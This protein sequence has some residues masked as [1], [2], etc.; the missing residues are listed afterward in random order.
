MRK[1]FS[2]IELIF[3]IF[4]ILL[5]SS[6]FY[7]KKT[8]DKLQV[9]TERLILY[10]KQT[11]YQAL[12]DSKE[13][14]NNPLWHKKRWTFKFFRCRKRVGGFYY[15]IYSDENMKGH[16]GQDESLIDPLTKKRVYSTNSC[17][18][19]NK[20]SKYV[21][22]T[23]EFDI[24]DINIS[25]NKT[26]SVGQISFGNNGKIY[27][28]QSPKENLSFEFEIHNSC[29]ITLIDNKNQSSTIIIEAKTG[30]I[31]RKN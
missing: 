19:N 30:Y 4:L 25:C 29:E 1:S 12:I 22:L 16:P 28:K 18:V 24:K 17:K 10:L 23:K 6:F 8:E 9:A 3:T 31:F 15:T 20:N 14:K 13:E 11:R 27:A 2:L 5:V 7:L 21:L 26:N